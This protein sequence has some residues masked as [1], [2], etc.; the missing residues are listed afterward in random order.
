MSEPQF[1][2]SVM[3]RHAGWCVVVCLIGGGQE[4]N[5]GEAGLQEWLTA[6]EQNY[7]HWKVHRSDRLTHSDYLGDNGAQ[8]ST[9]GLSATK[10]PELHL[11]V[12]VR[13]FRAELVSDFV[14][15]LIDGD[16]KRA[17]SL[18]ERLSNYPLA[19]TRNLKGV[20]AWL[21]QNARG[22]ERM[23]LVASSNA[24]RLKPVGLHVKAKIDPAV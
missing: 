20:R 5:T 13:S 6:I 23:G 7:P 4:I 3:D 21:R 17:K 15:A 2:M 18:R 24:M 12:S 11:S 14:G 1:L 8:M 19:L 9:R 22:T 10:T 16:Y